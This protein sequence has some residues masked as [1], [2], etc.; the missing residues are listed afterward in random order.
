M[1]KITKTKISVAK[2][3]LERKSRD[4]EMYLKMSTD[5]AFEIS[6]LQKELKFLKSEK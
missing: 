4:L 6:L 3:L 1:N 2:G 5:V